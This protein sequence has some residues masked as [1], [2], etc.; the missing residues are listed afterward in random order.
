LG[1]RSCVNVSRLGVS[2]QMAYDCLAILEQTGYSDRQF[3]YLDCSEERLTFQLSRRPSLD[4][5][6]LGF[7]DF[8]AFILTLSHKDSF[9]YVFSMRLIEVKSKR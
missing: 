6:L 3:S 4:D 8:F 5:N 9:L 7:F 2:Q 1:L